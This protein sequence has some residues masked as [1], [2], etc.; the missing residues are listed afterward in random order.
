MK[1]KRP[2]KR[3][4][5]SLRAYSKR[6]RVSVEA[7]SKAISS[8][9]LRQSVVWVNKRPKIANAALADQEWAANT[10]LAK[11][12]GAVKEREAA[13]GPSDQVPRPMSQLTAASVREKL[14]RVQKLEFDYL[15]ASGEFVNAKEVEARMTEIFARC[16]TKLLGLPTR[17]KGA[18]PHLALTD[19]ATLEALVREALEDLATMPAN[20]SGAAA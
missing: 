18:L 16:R 20:S 19:V 3:P 1:R 11:A 12:P 13:S 10:D 15:V 6:R 8:G 5:L 2:T 9:R 4:V 17:A 7:V 14:L